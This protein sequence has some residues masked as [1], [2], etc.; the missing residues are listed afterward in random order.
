MSDPLQDQKQ[1]I[2]TIPWH[3]LIILDACRYDAFLQLYGQYLEGDLYVVRSRASCTRFWLRETWTK[4][5][6]YGDITYISQNMYMASKVSLTV[7]N[8]QYPHRNAFKEIVDLFLISLSPCL[9]NTSAPLYKGRKVI[10]YDI[11]HR[12]NMGKARH[13]NWEGYLANL[14]YALL[15]VLDLLPQLE[16]M[17]VVTSDHGEMF[18]K[19]EAI[20]P[21]SKDI[22][23]LLEVPWLENAKVKT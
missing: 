22:P 10:H 5:E 7:K 6:D 16:G 19:G 15:H 4:L 13:N 12:P 20:H 21:C 11:P 2:H 23:V 8:W 3:N 17:T 14:E 1:L 18:L 9:M